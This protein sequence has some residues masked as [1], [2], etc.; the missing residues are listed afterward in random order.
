[1]SAPEHA[2]PHVHRRVV[3]EGRVQGVGFRYTC[4]KIARR[5]RVNGYVKNL[6]NGQV[7]LAV[8][9]TA[10]VVEQFFAAVAAAFSG[11]I[12]RSS[13]SELEPVDLPA[14]FHIRY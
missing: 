11:Y 10:A 1:M 12:E 9:G 13:S 5:Y 7:E 8:S 2:D 6:T 14:D 3:Y 4:A